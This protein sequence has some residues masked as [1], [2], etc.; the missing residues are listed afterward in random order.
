MWHLQCIQHPEQWDRCP[1]VQVA[2]DLLQVQPGYTIEK[3]ILGLPHEESD[4]PSLITAIIVFL[5][6]EFVFQGCKIA[7]SQP[8]KMHYLT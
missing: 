2:R 3:T 1:L 6:E 7:T 4:N 8:R 5:L